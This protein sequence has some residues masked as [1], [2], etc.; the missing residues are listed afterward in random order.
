MLIDLVKNNRSVRGYDQTRVVTKE[1]LVSMIE[2]ARICPVAR[3]LQ[4]IKY[5]IVLDADELTLINN[6]IKYAAAHP[7][8]KLPHRG[9]EP[10]AFIIICNDE[11]QNKTSNMDYINLGIAAQ[12]ITLAATELDLS[13]CMI[14]SFNRDKIKKGLLL[15]DN[16]NPLLVVS[17]G[18]SVES[19]HVVE[20]NSNEDSTYY[21][22]EKNTHYVPKKKIEDIIIH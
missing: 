13:G 3:N 21:R 8:W 14:A 17:I 7:E 5:K 1:E 15:D 19:I 2:H 18:K 20:I 16:V 11:S 22:D 10:T 12:T 9:T 6:N 4:T